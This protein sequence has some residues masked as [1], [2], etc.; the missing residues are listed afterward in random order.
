MAKTTSSGSFKESLAQSGNI[1]SSLATTPPAPIY[2]LMGE[3]SYFIDKIE[4]A[5]TN[6][7]L[8]TEARDFNL[9]I[10]Y[11]KDSTPGDIALTCRRYPMMSPYQMVIVREAQTLAKIEELESYAKNPTTTTVLILCVKGKNLDK[12]TAFY[13]ALSKNGTIFESTPPRDYELETFVREELGR[14]KITA[15]AKSIGM[16]CE[17]IGPNLAKLDNELTKLIAFLPDNSKVI[18][19]EI[20]EQNVGIS[21]D[22]NIFELTKALSMRNNHRTLMIA[23]HFARNPKNYPLVVTMATL[24]NHF[25]RIIM[26]GLMQW[27]ARRKSLPAPRDADIAK[28]LGVS[29]YFVSEYTSAVRN[30]PLKASFA[31]LGLLRE[32]D[33]KSK[34]IGSGTTDDGE[35][36]KELLL[37]ISV[38]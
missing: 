12:R 11:G 34:G 18:T 5:L 26:V 37:R 7:L 15:D 24:F 35:L 28:Q 2:T 9:T 6:S 36:L 13:K 4:Q 38:L 20:I 21:K 33:M 10:L 1:I 19:P 16:L 14:R 17:F 22:Y 8:P 23:D 32:Y 30:Y 31:I 3:E 29:P 25:Q 27:D